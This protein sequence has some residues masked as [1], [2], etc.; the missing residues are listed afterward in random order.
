M[1]DHVRLKCVLSFTGPTVLL[2]R[3]LTHHL[4]LLQVS[5]LGLEPC[6]DNDPCKFALIS[7]GTERGTVRYILQAAT[8]E[9]G[10]AWVADVGRI[11]ETQRDFLNGK[12]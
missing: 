3:S 11:L 1:K 4:S 6:V 5:S 9:I 10:Q 7:R 2:L 8:P 12:G